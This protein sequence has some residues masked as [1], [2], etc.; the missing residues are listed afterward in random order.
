MTRIRSEKAA[1]AE[2]ERKRRYEKKRQ[3]NI[4]ARR[5]ALVKR[6]G[7]KCVGCGK[8]RGLEFNH[9]K[10]RDWWTHGTWRR[11]AIA[12]YE[13]EADAGLLD[14]RCRK[15]NCNFYPEEDP[16]PEDW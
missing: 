10:K 13:Q 14:L 5:R 12:K 7:G 3:K 8:K 15:C 1:I 2:R 4:R 9:L 16:M 6:L 11:D